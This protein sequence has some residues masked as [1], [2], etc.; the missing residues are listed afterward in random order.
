MLLH[1]SANNLCIHYSEART[2]VKERDVIYIFWNEKWH[3]I[4]PISSYTGRVSVIKLYF[5]NLMD[6][7]LEIHQTLI[8]NYNL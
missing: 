8:M 4:L 2:D 6:K 1:Y 3:L 7:K 5:K